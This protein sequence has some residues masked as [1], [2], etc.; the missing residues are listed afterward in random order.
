[1]YDLDDDGSI[2][3]DEVLAVLHMMV[4]EN[5]RLVMLFS[6]FYPYRLLFTLKKKNIISTYWVT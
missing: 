1:M 5:I 6:A 4:G 3:R 2:T